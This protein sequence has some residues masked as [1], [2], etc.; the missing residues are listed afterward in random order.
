M[1]ASS[2]YATS[3]LF[4]HI[5]PA[6][7]VD[8]MTQPTMADWEA[9]DVRIGTVIRAEPNTGSRQPALALW[10][11]LGQDAVVQSSARITDGYAVSDMVDKQVVVV[12]GFESMRVGGFRSDVLV[13]GAP[14]TRGVVLLSP[15]MPVDPGSIVA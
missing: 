9:L 3:A 2:Q 4:T 5:V 14:T 6:T 7:T 8:V 12:C 15:D 10:I 11:D 1:A 13:L